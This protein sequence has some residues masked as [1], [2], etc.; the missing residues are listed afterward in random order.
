MD[1][2]RTTDWQ[3]DDDHRFTG[4][5]DPGWAQ[6]RA[7]FGGI[8]TAGAL[9]LMRH[10]VP[11]GRPCVECHTRYVG[12]L[13]P[14]AFQAEVSVLRSGRSIT[15]AEVRITGEGGLATVVLAT[16]AARRDSAIAVAPRLERPDRPDPES[17]RPLPYIQGVT[18]A[19]IDRM[20]MRWTDGTG[21]FSGSTEPVVGGWVRIKSGTALDGAPVAL[22]LLD[23][24]PSPVLPLLTAPAPA[25]TVSWSAWLHHVP[26]RGDG[27]WWYREDAD[28]GEH[29]GVVSTGQLFAPD[30]RLAGTKTQLVAVYDR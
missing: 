27:W 23:T 13:A 16:F 18:P 25:S 24:F 9:R 14:A 30:G 3:P 26:A 6:G 15:Q 7:V 17:L 8:Q 21:P 28:F 10:V 29:G 11:E 20:E 12:P 5:F 2:D 22:A 1:F 4:T 19:F